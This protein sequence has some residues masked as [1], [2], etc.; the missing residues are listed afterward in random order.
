MLASAETSA[1]Q[2]GSICLRG[3]AGT[4][5]MASIWADAL[6]VFIPDVRA[7]WFGRFEFLFV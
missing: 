2:S 5:K 6:R 1:H 3:G 4:W 7:S